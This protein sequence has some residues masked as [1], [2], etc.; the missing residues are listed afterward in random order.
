LFRTYGRLSFTDAV[1]VVVMR[2]L[3]IEVIYSFD[4]DFDGILGV[5]RLTTVEGSINPQ[6]Y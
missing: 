5:V 4:R 3:D 1:S 2:D 6:G